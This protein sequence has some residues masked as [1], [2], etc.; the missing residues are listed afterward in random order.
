MK[1]WVGPGLYHT[2]KYGTKV[3]SVCSSY[4]KTSTDCK[5][6]TAPRFRPPQV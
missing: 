5:F 6:G 1:D 4:K 3:D 2:E